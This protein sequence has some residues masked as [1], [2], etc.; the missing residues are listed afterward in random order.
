[1][2]LIIVESPAKARTI[3]HFLGNQY[4]VLASYGHVKDLPKSRLGIDVEN[5]FQPAYIVPVKARKNVTAL[6]KAGLKAKE[7]IL[8]TD[9]DREG[10][11]IAFHIQKILNEKEQKTYQR[12]VFHEITEN[13]I[14]EALKNPR[15]IDMNLVNAQQARRVLDRLVGYELSPFLWKKV[16]KG[17]SAGR[18][19]SA[20]L[21]IIVDREK[22]IKAFQAQEFWEIIGQFQPLNKKETFEAKLFKINEKKLEKLSFNNQEEAEA[23]KE[24]L[25]NSDSQITQITY[26]ETK[27]HPAPPFITSSL[28]QTAWQK[29]KYPAKKTMFIA[30]HLYE[31]ISL[32]QGPTG[33][34]TYM[35]TDSFN[36]SAESLNTAKQWLSNNIGKDY[37]LDE[38][39]YFK[40]RSKLAQEAH[41]AIRP[42]QPQLS[43]ESIKE[44]LSSEEFKIYDLI[45]RRFMASQM[46]AAVLKTMSVEISSQGK[47]DLYFFNTSG[48][49]IVFDGFWK[50]YPKGE[51]E[52]TLPNLKEGEELKIKEI[53]PNQHFTQPPPRYNEASIIKALE[54]YGIGRPSTYA[55]IISVIQN[56]RYVLK[57]DNKSFCP[58]EIGIIVSDLLSQHFPEIVDYQFTANLENDLDAIANGDKVWFETVRQFYTPF[59]EKLTQKYTD[60]SKQELVLDEK[61]DEVCEK[62]GRPMIIKY[63]RFGKFMACSGF[64]ECKNAKPLKSNNLGIKCPKCQEGDIVMRRS[65]RGKI[66]YGCS[67]W[68]KCD[69]ISNF[70]P[71][72]RFCPSCGEMLVE[73][74]KN[75]GCSNKN[76]TY[77]SPLEKNSEQ[78]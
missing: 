50:I 66:F 34:I 28:Q 45:W 43:P 10:E 77:E 69:Y 33:L 5:N 8:A 23:V 62:C 52:N 29:Y 1:M 17:L 4:K 58:T 59:K 14:L 26:K 12:I 15:E 18:V 72:G 74:K 64:P 76:C 61:T 78:D 57:D 56:R 47:K 11:S 16:L 39:R 7:I 22:E 21:K 60:V 3:S 25:K 42:T 68:P 13:A 40:N 27:R 19:Q 31:G 32:P 70:K 37:A 30:Q 53:I 54:E 9:E 38:P 20:A 73:K 71:L 2:N 36:L 67:L 51:T 6:K 65:K 63:G 41:E 46:P 24:D 35:R 75:V 55:T 48:S 49:E 44:S